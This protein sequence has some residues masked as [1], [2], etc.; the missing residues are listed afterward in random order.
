MTK[1]QGISA[2]VLCGISFVLA[3][4]GTA[5]PFWNYVSVG[6]KWASEGLWQRC[7]NVLGSTKCVGIADSVSGIELEGLFSIYYVTTKVRLI[8]NVMF[9][10]PTQNQY[11]MIYLKKQI[12][13]NLAYN[14]RCYRWQCVWVASSSHATAQ[15]HIFRGNWWNYCWRH[16]FPF[17]DS[18]REVVS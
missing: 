18:R 10:T 12:T 4:V 8:Q 3:V 7:N 11:R 1:V 17:A 5:I 2:M 16:S 13:T 6:D 15:L 14:A 9:S